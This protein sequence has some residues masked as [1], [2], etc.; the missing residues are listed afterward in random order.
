MRIYAY[1]YVRSA[2]GPTVTEVCERG[3]V[4][5]EPAGRDNSTTQSEVLS[6][7]VSKLWN[8]I[9]SKPQK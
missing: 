3:L 8:D 2:V 9:Y 1:E 4:L 7:F 5:D 6:P